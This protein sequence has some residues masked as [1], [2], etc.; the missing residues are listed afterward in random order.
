MG[1]TG[2]CSPSGANTNGDAQH[3]GVS[4]GVAVLRV[5]YYLRFQFL[6]SWR[7]LDH[8]VGV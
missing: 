2:T 4:V 6:R 7:S 5:Y 1:M 3:V 8:G